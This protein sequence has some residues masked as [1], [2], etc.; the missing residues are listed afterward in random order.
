LDRSKESQIK[1]PADYSGDRIPHETGRHVTII[2]VTEFNSVSLETRS[3]A[4]AGSR[5]FQSTFCNGKWNSSE[6]RRH[7]HFLPNGMMG[8]FLIFERLQY[9]EVK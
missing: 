7:A 9:A 5:A 2:S 6:D 3:L 8:K 1:S 4:H